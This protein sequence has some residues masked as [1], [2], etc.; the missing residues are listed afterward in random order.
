MNPAGFHCAIVI[1]TFVIPVSAQAT[2]LGKREKLSAAIEGEA[3]VY[4]RVDGMADPGSSEALLHL[5]LADCEFTPAKELNTVG[6]RG[7]AC[8]G[9]VAAEA[10]DFRITWKSVGATPGDMFGSA[11]GWSSTVDCLLAVGAPQSGNAGPG[12]VTI[13]ERSGRR[14]CRFE[15]MAPGDRFGATLLWLSSTDGN[16]ADS[17][18]IVVSAPYASF[19]RGAI[20]VYEVTASGVRTIWTALGNGDE[21]KLGQQLLATA[22]LDSDGMQDFLATSRNKSGASS[23]T[24]FG[25]VEGKVLWSTQLPAGTQEEYRSPFA[26]I[27]NVGDW[28][29]NAVDDIGLI[30]ARQDSIVIVAMPS[31]VALQR[32]SLDA[33]ILMDGAW[34]ISVG[35]LDGDRRDEALLCTMGRPLSGQLESMSRLHLLLSRSSRVIE[36]GYCEVPGD[37]SVDTIGGWPTANV[38]SLVAG[39]FSRVA[40]TE[41][42]HDAVRRLAKMMGK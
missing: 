10:N 4:R 21:V 33:G 20:A 19:E 14:V 13:F 16:S 15:G 23:V 5:A 12:Y 37:I 38:T 28:D 42:D 24:A 29:G 25:S 36:V 11:I 41:V 2:E 39:G 30:A 3:V 17:A 22:D 35:E 40:V 27:A 7:V 18:F 1:L 8:I 26:C 9:V 6:K 34:L 32:F 31:G